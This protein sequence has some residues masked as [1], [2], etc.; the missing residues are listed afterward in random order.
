MTVALA[1]V[2]VAKL[3]VVTAVVA[4]PFPGAVAVAA[5][6]LMV[7][8]VMADAFTRLAPM[9]IAVM[10]DAF[11]RVAPMVVAVPRTAVV[12]SAAAIVTG[13]TRR[14][15]RESDDRRQNV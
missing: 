11:A 9:V 5:V 12:M 1:T 8:A 3:P 7:I 4:A 13:P 14:Y 6:G 2:T 15:Q 10:A